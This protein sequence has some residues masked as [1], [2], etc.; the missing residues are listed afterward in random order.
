MEAKKY[1]NTDIGL[2]ILRIGIGIMFVLHGYP[3]IQGG[4]KTWTWLG[5]NG[6]G[7]IGIDIFPIF[8]GFMAAFSE[9][10]GAILFALGIYTRICALSLFLTMFVASAFHYVSGDSIFPSHSV[11]LAIV[12]LGVFFAGGGQYSI[13]KILKNKK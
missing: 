4:I 11:E 5:T 1:L 10:F 6:M 3:K 13:D 12:F 8:W 2:L 7:A 9:F